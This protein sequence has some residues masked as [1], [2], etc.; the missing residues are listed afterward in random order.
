MPVQKKSLFDIEE[1]KLEWRGQWRIETQYFKNDCVMFDGR[2]YKCIKD[3]PF[4]YVVTQM[5]RLGQDHMDTIPQRTVLRSKHPF[6]TEY[7]ILM[8]ASVDRIETW[9]MW[10]QYEVGEMCKA[11]ENYYVCINK[12]I[13]LI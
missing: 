3:T 6:D 13:F 1:L 10:T 8:L 11:A 9:S 2:T 5:G 7:W 12:R 4:E